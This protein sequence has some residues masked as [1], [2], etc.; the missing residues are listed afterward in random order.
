M[1]H[2]R[3]SYWPSTIALGILLSVS[4]ATAEEP[5]DAAEAF[6]A[7]LAAKDKEAVL[8]LLV[9]EV[10]ILESGGYEASRD[11]YASHHLGADMEF[12]A[13]TER[14]V[15]KSWSGRQGEVAWVLSATRTQGHFRDRDIDVR[16]VETMLPQQPCHHLTRDLLAV[17][18]QRVGHRR[19][20]RLI[21][22][23]QLPHQSVDVLDMT[24][25][26]RH[27]RRHVRQHRCGRVEQV[28]A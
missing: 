25:E 23:L 14:T 11:E 26:E 19:A 18:H 12:T 8:A 13:A 15:E 1:I 2:R 3:S 24:V 10:V 5:E 27:E 28:V 7:A 16:G 21:G 22:G 20:R 9:P 4:M 17:R 6:H